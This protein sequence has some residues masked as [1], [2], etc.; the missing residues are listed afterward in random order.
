VEARRPPPAVLV[1]PLLGPVL[2]PLALPTTVV[3]ARRKTVELP[4]PA[5]DRHDAAA[6]RA[7]PEVQP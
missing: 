6:P 7:A 2:L 3:P 4:L 5:E 1:L